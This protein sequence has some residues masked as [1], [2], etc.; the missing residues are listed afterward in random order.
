MYKDRPLY[1]SLYYEGVYKPEGSSVHV[2][3]LKIIRKFHSAK[4]FNLY[5]LPIDEIEINTD[6]GD[7]KRKEFINLTHRFSYR[8]GDGVFTLSGKKRLLETIEAN[9]TEEYSYFEDRCIK[10]KRKAANNPRLYPQVKY[11]AEICHKSANFEES[12]AFALK[13]KENME[14][15]DRYTTKGQMLHDY[16]TLI[17][18]HALR[19]GA[20]DEAKRHLLLSLEVSPSPMM[21]S[22]GPNMELAAELL[23]QGEKDTV[24]RYLDGS[25]KIWRDKSIQRWKKETSENKKPSFYS[26]NF[27]ESDK[28][29]NKTSSC[30]YD[31]KRKQYKKAF[32]SCLDEASRGDPGAQTLRLAKNNLS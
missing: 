7:Y 15:F 14:A 26:R 32:N 17:G 21:T 13:L 28:K 27:R 3:V 5:Y 31:Y 30:Y 25:A 9:F 20:I 12:K 2:F 8:H 4:H 22:F 18:R 10:A 23:K 24:L 16:H 19:E 29:Q 1:S 11:A 6:V